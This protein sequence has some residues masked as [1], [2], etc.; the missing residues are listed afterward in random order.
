MVQFVS[1]VLPPS[2]EK[3]C[4]HVALDAVIRDQMK[5]TRMGMPS[6]VS[7]ARKTP[8]PSA[9]PPRTGTSIRPG[10]RPSSHQIDH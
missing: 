6:K 7:S 1:H 5:R 8:T 4:S 2:S 9:K 10:V 3:V